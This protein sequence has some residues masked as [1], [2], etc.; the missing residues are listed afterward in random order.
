MAVS[1]SFCS[2]AEAGI[3]STL[4]SSSL[5]PRLPFQLSVA[6]AA[7]DGK[8]E[9]KPGNEVQAT[10]SWKGSLGTRCKRRKAGREAWERGASHGALLASEDGKG[11][12]NYKIQTWEA[13][14]NEVQA[15]EHAGREAWERGYIG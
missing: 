3:F 11:K 14:G 10:E 7:S 15:T 12:C 2:Y 5:V 1:T 13:L 9:G 8:L 6:S 4:I